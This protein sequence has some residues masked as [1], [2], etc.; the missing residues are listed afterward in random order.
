MLSQAASG[1][2]HWECY[3]RSYISFLAIL[4]ARRP[5]Q[6]A[7][8]ASTV[9]ITDRS[10]AAGSRHPTLQEEG[11]CTQVWGYI[12]ANL[13]TSQQHWNVA[14]PALASQTWH[15]PSP[16]FSLNF[17]AMYRKPCVACL[18]YPSPT[19][20]YRMAYYRLYVVSLFSTT[21]L[22]P[23]CLYTMVGRSRKFK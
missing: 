7:A 6:L 8:D 5:S 18:R 16:L 2:W 14:R 4:A 17:L 12:F 13:T 10:S 9:R 22:Q 1:S 20:A 15:T 23:R 21:S 11:F 19:I 3:E